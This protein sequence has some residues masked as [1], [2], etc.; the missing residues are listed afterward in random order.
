MSLQNKLAFKVFLD[1]SLYEKAIK[2]VDFMNNNL[3]VSWINFQ[4]EE[5]MKRT[6]KTDHVYV[7]HFVQSKNKEYK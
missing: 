2:K 1:C 7:L 4:M 6:D 3:C 5:F